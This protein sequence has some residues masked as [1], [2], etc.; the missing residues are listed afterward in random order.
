[1]LKPSIIYLFQVCVDL[2]FLF[3]SKFKVFFFFKTTD[4]S[5]VTVCQIQPKYSFNFG[6]NISI[7]FFVAAASIIA[8]SIQL[9]G[10]RHASQILSLS[11]SMLSTEI[12]FLLKPFAHALF[13]YI[14]K[15][16]IANLPTALRQ[17]V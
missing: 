1:M 4:T 11:K 9:Q 17:I 7:E 6:Y 15:K 12:Q 13:H 5:F 16:V 14:Y 3:G 8:Y 2:F 10:C